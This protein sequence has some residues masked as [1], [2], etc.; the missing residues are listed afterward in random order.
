LNTMTPNELM[1]KMNEEMSD[2][3]S[4]DE[5]ETPK[6]IRFTP[7]VIDP[8]TGKALSDEEANQVWLDIFKC[9]ENDQVEGRIVRKH[10]A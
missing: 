10:T 5:E 2:E 7:K 4:E 9:I 6:V 8:D 1:E 3:E